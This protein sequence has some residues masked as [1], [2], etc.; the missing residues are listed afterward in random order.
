MEPMVEQIEDRYEQVP[1]QYL[2]DGGF[3]NKEAIEKV[4]DQGSIVYAPVSKPKD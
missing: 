1:E 3:A 4:T 2:V